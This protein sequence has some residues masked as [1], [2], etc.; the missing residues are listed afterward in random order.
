MSQTKR[1]LLEAEKR[2]NETKYLV[3][4]RTIVEAKLY[5]QAECL[6]SEKIAT[7]DDCLSLHDKI[8]RLAVTLNLNRQ[9]T[10]NFSSLLVS[11]FRETREHG[12]RVSNETCQQLDRFVKTLDEVCHKLQV[13]RN[14]ALNSLIHFGQ[15]QSD[16]TNSAVNFIRDE[17]LGGQAQANQAMQ[18]ALGLNHQSMQESCAEWLKN[19]NEAFE[20]FNEMCGKQIRAIDATSKAI[21]Q[22]EVYL[23]EKLELMLSKFVSRLNANASYAEAELSSIK[24]SISASNSE[25]MQTQSA[26]V[27]LKNQLNE[28][29]T[30]VNMLVSIKKNADT[31]IDTVSRKLEAI[32][33]ANERTVEKLSELDNQVET[34]VREYIHEMNSQIE[35][36]ISEPIKAMNQESN[37]KLKQASALVKTLSENNETANNEFLRSMELFKTVVEVLIF[38]I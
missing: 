3:N 28:L 19:A 30:V 25:V 32:R 31:S 33:G 10:N 2:L 21:S 35:I 13:S 11:C 8:D 1:D 38:I 23:G 20:T 34:D 12:A 5:K 9:T 6:N 14:T 26:N 18:A 24:E 36:N 15:K 7:Q 22:F 16:Q 27:L 4:E 29:N 17:I 37:S